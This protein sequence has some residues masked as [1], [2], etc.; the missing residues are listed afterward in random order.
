MSTRS[1]SYRS[2]TAGTA[3]VSVVFPSPLV[4][5]AGDGAPRLRV[6]KRFVRLLVVVGNGSVMVAEYDQVVGLGM[7][8]NDH[9]VFDGFPH[10]VDKW[11]VWQIIELGQLIHLKV[12]FDDALVRGVCR[13]PH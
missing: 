12:Q 2:V 7:G 10:M 5:M 4:G 9:Q 13:D 1:G 8:D 11:K 6:D 3:A